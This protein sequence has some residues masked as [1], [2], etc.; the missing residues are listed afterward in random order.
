MAGAVAVGVAVVG[1][2]GVRVWV[3]VV[4][5]VVVVVAVVV[6]VAVGVGVGVGVGVAGWVGVGVVM[7]RR[8]LT[9]RSNTVLV[10][11]RSWKLFGAVVPKSLTEIRHAA[12]E[13]ASIV[14]ETGGLTDTVW[15]DAQPLPGPW[16]VQLCCIESFGVLK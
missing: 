4:V 13:A 15:K 8:N 10:R 1:G 12:Q 2:V 5:E 9:K 6:A 16:Y 14:Y 7:T 11:N 3:G